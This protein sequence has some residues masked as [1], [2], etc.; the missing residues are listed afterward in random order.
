MLNLKDYGS[1]CS[2]PKPMHTRI[3]KGS[4]KM[5]NLRLI[6]MVVLTLNDG[7]ENHCFMQNNANGVGECF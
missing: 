7:L 1:M 5:I 3:E 6:Q 4:M 2:T